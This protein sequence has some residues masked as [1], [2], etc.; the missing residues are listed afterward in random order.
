M[1]PAPTTARTILIV[2]D[3]PQMA[4]NLEIALTNV[5]GAEI[6]VAGTGLEAWGMLQE[7]AA[8]VAAV[9][10]DLEMPRMDGFELISR[11]RAV[12]R[13]ARTP[14]IVASGSSDPDWTERV[15]SLG[16]NACFAKPY[17]PR[18]LRRKLETLL[19]ECA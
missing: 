7:E 13:Y 11:M 17:S 10:T 2:E 14:I 19:G 16:A 18:A 6:R 15:L 8:R 12:P 5:D 4:A 1:K 3:S 9:I